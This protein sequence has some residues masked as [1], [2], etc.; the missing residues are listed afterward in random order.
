MNVSNPECITYKVNGCISLDTN[1]DHFALTEIDH[2]G[3]IVGTE[4][5]PFKWKR[6]KTNQIKH[7]LRECAVQIV[8]RC[9][10]TNKPLVIEDLDFEDKKND[11]EYEDEKQNEKL[12]NFAYSKI[13][14]I[15]ERRAVYKGVEC[16][17]VDP[18]YTSK[19]GRSKYM[20]LKGLSVHMAASYVIGRRGLGFKDK[21]N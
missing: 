17:K 3:N 8:E 2:Y 20:K 21:L 6:R 5:I 12:S 10:Q 15:L 13:K 7:D 16:I 9:I 4:I 1:I 11:M 19:I 18:A 14:E